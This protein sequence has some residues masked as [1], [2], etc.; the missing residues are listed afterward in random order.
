MM[1]LNLICFIIYFV[2]I[3][4][5]AV[6]DGFDL[7]VGVLHLFEKNDEE[8]RLHIKSIGPVWDGNEVWLIAAGGTLF[9]AF[10]KVYATVFSS[11]YLA[12]VLLL[13]ALIGRA[14][15]VEF[16]NNVDSL[17]WKRF[18]DTVFGI[19]SILTSFLLGVTA[20]NI[21]RGLPLDENFTF[22]GSFIG[23]LNPYSL[24]V[25][26]LAL[27]A[28]TLHGCSYLAIKTEAE[29]QERLNRWMPR[30]WIIFVS[31]LVAAVAVSIPVSSHIFEGLS[32]KFPFWIFMMITLFSILLMPFVQKKRLYS[33]SFLLSAMSIV[34]ILGIAAVGTFPVM[35]PSITNIDNSL[36]VYNSASTART[37]NI[38]LII[39]VIGMPFIIA[40]T[41]FIYR[42]FRGKLGPAPKK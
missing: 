30:L 26:L 12:L 3:A 4:G 13:A 22:T 33:Q 25:G 27:A 16:R 23:L 10:P 17:K 9:A 8:R 20:G 5:Y 2:L 41:I 29:L 28:F 35:V 32:H 34:G 21:L 19:G 38:I 15:S 14:V 42:V 40:Y 31:L 37:L 39:T 6:L 11:F 24:L 36:T 1:D 7:G 18:W